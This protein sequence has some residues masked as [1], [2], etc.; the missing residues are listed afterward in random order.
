MAPFLLLTYPNL[1]G[2]AY[3]VALLSILTVWMVYRLG[4]E[5][6]GQSA[7]LIAAGVC[8]ISS[9]LV[10]AA[11]FSWNPNPA[12]F[13]SMVWLYALHKAWQKDARWIA[14]AIA[15]IAILIQ[16]H[17]VAL[18]TAPVTAMWWGLTVWRWH[19][20]QLRSI[21]VATLVGV[22]V[23]MLSLVPQV[24]FD[25]RHGGQ[26]AAAFRYFFTRE[27][28]SFLRSSSLGNVARLLSESE[29]KGIRVVMELLVGDRGLNRLI[30]PA[31]WMSIV[32][33]GVKAPREAR[34]SIVLIVFALFVT[35]WGITFY[36]GSV[37]DHYILFTMPWT[38]LLF[39]WLCTQW[40]RSLPGKAVVV[41]ALGCV[42]VWNLIHE[43]LRP[44]GWPMSRMRETS[45]TLLRRVQQDE[46][47]DIVLLSSSGDLEGQ[48][49][50]Y[51]LEVSAKPP[52]KPEERG[53]AET[54]FIINEDHVLQ[55]VL[56][57][58]V[59]EIV[60]FPNKTPQEVY[61]VRDGPEI[62]VLRR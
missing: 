44:L 2:P 46:K 6:L 42:V 19:K 41:V 4:K 31:I 21:I 5:M 38:A 30:Y 47:Y 7:A 14:V 34:R 55:N 39:G 13:V 57:S 36:R 3:A 25:L 9:V 12:P 33:Y 37:F 1:I 48:N 35:I 8:S 28:S 45:E 16:L 23:F 52:V 43:P 24:V 54:L 22:G 15:C 59:Y 62:T 20:T 29:G 17:Y 56:A 61:T 51:F 40:W 26:N 49:Y 60:T 18:L 10:A 32:W 50:R 11:R 27:D 58:P 53:N